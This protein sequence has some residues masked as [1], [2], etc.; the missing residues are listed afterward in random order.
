M[1][2]NDGLQRL[3][4]LIGLGP[5]AQSPA[6][7]EAEDDEGECGAKERPARSDGEALHAVGIAAEGCE[8]RVADGRWE[9]DEN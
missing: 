1:T 6:E 2:Y 8:R 5:P 3:P 4:L 9:G 7:E